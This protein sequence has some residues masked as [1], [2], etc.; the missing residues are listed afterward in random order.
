MRV[1]VLGAGAIGAAVAEELFAHEAVT[2]V[3]VCDRHARSLQTLQERLDE[4]ALLRT[5]QLDARDTATIHPILDGS[6]CVV[7]C[8][9]PSLNPALAEL[10]MDVGSHFCDLGGHDDPV[11]EQLALADIAREKTCWIVPGCGL[12]PGLVNVLCLHAVEQFDDPEAAHLR[13]GDVPLEPED[14]FRFRISWSAE[15]VL[16]DYTNPVQLIEDGRAREANPLSRKERIDF[17]APFDDMEAFCTQGGLSTLTHALEGRL[18]K[19]DH[20]TVRWPG[21]AR[22]MRFLLGLGFG[23]DRSID[24]RTHLTYRDVL[25]RRMRQRLGG[26]HEDAVLLRVLVRGQIDGQTRTLVYQMVE[27]YAAGHP[28]TAMAHCTAVPAAAVAALLAGGT[29]VGGGAAPPE[30]AVPFGAYLDLVQERGLH[31]EEHWLDGHAPVE[32]RPDN[33]DASGSEAAARPDEKPHRAE[34]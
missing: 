12:A 30:N 31:V 15:K 25:V 1:T 26:D 29:P 19:L 2:Q 22:Q 13:V 23:E 18:Q 28:H 27:R 24:V 9:P 20:K 6:A 7:S 17:G 33:G 16:D 32:T 14:P 10:C 34:P 21:H 11:S 8:L 3:Q 5:F 4:D